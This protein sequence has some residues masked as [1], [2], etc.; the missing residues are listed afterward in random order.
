MTSPAGSTGLGARLADTDGAGGL[1]LRIVVFVG[2]A[3]D[4]AGTFAGAGGAAAAES[5]VETG[6][7]LGE[8]AGFGCT[9]AAFRVGAGLATTGAAGTGGGDALTLFFWTLGAGIAVVS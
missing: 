7:T 1:G 2:L 4:A 3:G 6:L 9:G 8:G 5:C